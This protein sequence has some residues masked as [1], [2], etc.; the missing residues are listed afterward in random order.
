M[1]QRTD[2]LKIISLLCILLLM[3][4]CR[5]NRTVQILWPDLDDSYIE[6]T[7]DWTRSGAVYSGIETEII[8]HATLKSREWQDAY[9][10][11]RAEV[12]S[13]SLEE[14]EEFA[15]ALARLYNSETEI[16]LS[17]FSPVPEHA[18]I[19][20]NDPLWSIFILKQDQKVYPLEIRPVREP[21]AQLR[22]FYPYVRQWRKNYILRFPIESGDSLLMV[23]SGPL[24]RIE[25]AW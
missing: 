22:T 3:A 1:R 5:E 21:L 10:L 20:F 7:R 13:M 8:V 4:G 23:M 2:F 24:G 19:R 16:F 11:K 12:Y 9:I 18:R 25:L 17:V 6:I 15:M 14:K